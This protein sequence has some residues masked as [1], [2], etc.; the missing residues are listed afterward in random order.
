LGGAT[1]V[2][3]NLA[4]VGVKPVMC[5]VIGNDVSGEK[6][7]KIL[8]DMN[9]PAS[10]LYVSRSRPT[11]V[12]TRVMA[13]HQQICRIDREISEELSEDEYKFLWDYFVRMLPKISGVI[14]SDY[15]KGVVS[16]PLIGKILVECR[17]R[18]LFVAVDP[19][20]RHFDLYKEVSV[21]TPNLK[22]AHTVIGA[23]HNHACS[24]E[25][26]K[27]LGWRIVEKLDCACL[28][29]TLSERGMALFDRSKNVMTLLP[30]MARTVYDVTGAGDTVISVY[31]A[32]M[33]SGAT[34]EE[35]AFLA[36]T[37][38]GLTIGQLGTAS[39]DP[40]SLLDACNAQ[41]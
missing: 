30:T 23:P 15:A 2:L 35:A 28:L 24:D 16:Q 14:I 4:A 34:P 27:S 19:K 22:E 1:N 31:T 40:K 21:L 37:A 11:T 12:K 41:L 20:E 6:L 8:E 18:N 32:A 13:S 26:I 39:V 10:G 9:C 29:I 33:V 38:A 36:N 25:E 3:Q 7:R 17:K 5:S